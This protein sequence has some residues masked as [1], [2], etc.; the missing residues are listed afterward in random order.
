[1]RLKN[2]WM[3]VAAAA[4][5]SAAPHIGAAQAGGGHLDHVY[6]DSF[7]NLVVQ[8]AAGYKRI[9]VGEGRLAKELR[10]Y[11]SGGEP[12]GAYS[13]TV[14]RSVRAGFSVDNCYRPPVLLKGRGYMYGLDEGVV[15]EPSGRC[16]LR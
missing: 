5:C 9:I 15:P 10:A 14:I 3:K 8:S 4:I 13:Q 16:P 12:T 6:A 2:L 7:G 1:M 11:T